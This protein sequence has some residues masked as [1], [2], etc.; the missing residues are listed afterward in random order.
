ME[1]AIV[2]IETTGSQLGPD[3]ITEIGVVITDGVKELHRYETLINPQA[4]IPR[5]ITH[6]TGITEEMVEDA[7][8]FEEVAEDI[9]ELLNERIFVAHN[10]NFD[11]K[12]VKSHMERAGFSIPSKRLCTVRLSRK[13]IPGYP[14]YSLGK[15]TA[16]LGFKHS[17]AHRAMG[18]AEVTAELFHLL[19]D[20]NTG[21]IEQALKSNSK[22]ATLPA[23]LPKENYQKLPDEP[24]VYYFHDAKGKVIYIGKAKNLK[25]RVTSHFTGKNNIKK[26]GFLENIFDVSF[27]LTGNEVIASLLEDAEIKH[28]WPAYNRA[29]KSQIQKFGVFRYEDQGGNIR[30]AINKINGNYKGIMQF[31][32]MSKARNWLLDKIEDYELSP[33]LCGMRHYENDQVSVDKHHKNIN[34]LLREY[35][36]LEETIVWKGRGRDSNEEA[37]VLME[38]GVYKGYGF[39]D[40]SHSVT[41]VTDLKTFIKPK[42]ETLMVKKILASRK[43]NKLKRVEIPQ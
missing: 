16:S 20:K 29:Q 9:Y 43:I 35:L 31:P 10:V 24:G 40:L 33:S 28:Y 39:V 22:E 23:N 5:F 1:F 27:E 3:C 21:Q 25:K 15:L 41:S 8:V 13:I 36:A 11:Y 17:N 19:F 32:T 38:N 14:S 6:L 2:D 4:R 42:H 18:D 37:F 34:K 30:L 26:R 12:I 7:P